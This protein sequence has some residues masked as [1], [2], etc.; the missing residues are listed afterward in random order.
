MKVRLRLNSRVLPVLVLVVL[1][2]EL[3]DPSMAWS[4]L[5]VVLGGG[6]LLGW[7]WARAL[8]G[9]LSFT[10]EMR[11]DWVQVGDVL[12]ERYSIVNDAGVPAT[13]VEISDYSSLPDYHASLATLVGAQSA[14]QLETRGMC[15]RRGLYTLGGTSLQSGDPL[16]IYTLT[17]EDASTRSLLVLPPVVPLPDIDV[18]QGGFTGEIHPRSRSAEP[19]V[20]AA[21]VRPYAPGDPLRLMHWP[22]TARHGAPFVRTLDG[23]SAADWWILLDLDGSVQAGEGWD[24]SSEHAVILAASLA[25]RGLRAGKAVGLALNAEQARWQAPRA[26]A[27]QRWV[28]MRELALARPG[29]AALGQFM[30]LAGGSFTRRSSLVIISANTDPTWLDALAGLRWRTGLIATVLLLDPLS[31]GGVGSASGMSALL[32]QSGISC[33][34]ITRELL[35][36]PEAHPGMAGRWEWRTSATG[37]AIALH[38]PAQADWRRLA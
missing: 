27:D 21:S 11:Y 37:R 22:S 20:A 19:S 38:K 35:N 6:W 32:Q 15:T 18:T 26:N 14:C 31:F 5:L 12:E 28:I 13:W 1:V 4:T 23:T 24:A 33:H 36:R 2:L 9:G 30:T 17:I 7:L 25:D 3:L 16:G 8:A 10:R 29:G 34:V